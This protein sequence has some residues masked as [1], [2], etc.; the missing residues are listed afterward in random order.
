MIWW[1]RSCNYH[2][3]S[4]PI[5]EQR[6]CHR[7]SCAADMHERPLL[8]HSRFDGVSRDDGRWLS[9]HWWTSPDSP[10]QSTVFLPKFHVGRRNIANATLDAYAADLGC[11]F[12]HGWLD[13]GPPQQHIHGNRLCDS[14][15]QSVVD[16]RPMNLIAGRWRKKKNRRVNYIHTVEFVE[17]G[18]Q[19]LVNKDES[20]GGGQGMVAQ[21]F[22]KL[23]NMWPCN[24]VM[25]NF[26]SSWMSDIKVNEVE[27]FGRCSSTIHLLLPCRG[28]SVPLCTNIHVL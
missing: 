19:M 9:R 13:S 20:V 8:S 27:P 14:P 15:W 23:A 10:T 6:R 7:C 25:K 16:R 4:V 24:T 12:L 17:V 11:P 21:Y 22:Y 2:W 28:T 1:M 3:W 5:A 18:K 26:A